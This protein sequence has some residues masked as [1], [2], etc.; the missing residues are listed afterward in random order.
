MKWQD[1]Y[2]E[3]MR[4]IVTLPYNEQEGYECQTA[5][6]YNAVVIKQGDFESQYLRVDVPGMK[7]RNY[8]IPFLLVEEGEI[9]GAGDADTSIQEEDYL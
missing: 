4:L 2:K 9:V 8:G 3:G 1:K 5:H 7:Y 6:T